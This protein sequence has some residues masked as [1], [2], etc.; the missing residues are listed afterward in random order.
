MTDTTSTF[1]TTNF[2]DAAIPEETRRAVAAVLTS[3]NLPDLAAGVSVRRVSGGASNENFVV[4]TDEGARYVLRLTAGG[5]FASRFGLDRW[6]GLEAHRA[7]QTAGVAPEL[8][9]AVLPD[10]HSLVAYVD[11]EVVD[12]VRIREAAVLDTC[13]G[14]LR[15]V[16]RSRRV[17][18]RFLPSAEVDRYRATAVAEGLALPADIGALAGLSHRIDTLMASSGAPEV[19]CHNDV[20]L[21]NFLSDGSSV[22]VLDWEYAANGNLFFDLAMVAANATFDDDETALMLASYF[23]DVRETDVAR[24][25]LQQFQAALREAMW[26]VIAK[27]ILWQTGWDYDA[28]A[29]KYFDKARTIADGPDV[30]HLLRL[31][32]PGAG[33]KQFYRKVLAR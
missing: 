27:P 22:A 7:A 14:A 26:S 32:G 23:G 20:Q 16:H 8:V 4:V 2:T 15:T 19:L 21:S 29:A 3:F 1:I 18:G 11:L 13:I 28:W 10:G 25:R 30:D 5:Q 9:A 12:E 6:R 17:S 24:V 31:A 33:D